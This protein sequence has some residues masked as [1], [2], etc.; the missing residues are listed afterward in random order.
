MARQGRQPQQLSTNTKSSKSK[1]GKKGGNKAKAATPESNNLDVYS[2]SSSSKRPRGD[3]DPAARASFQSGKGKNKKGKGKARQEESEEEDAEELASDGDD[4][5][6]EDL[7]SE[8]EGFKVRGNGIVEFTGMKPAGLKMGM[9]SDEEGGFGSGDDEDI[10]SDFSDEMSDETPKKQKKSVQSSKKSLP[11]TEIDLD[12]DEVDSEDEE[13]D[14]F[15]DV[16]EVFDREGDEDEEDSE[17]DS[18]SDEEIASDADSMDQDDDD[19]D[20]GALDKLDDFVSGLE[21]SKKRKAGDRNEDDSGKKKKRVILKERTEA[22]PEGEF[23]AVG[24]DSAADNRVQLED[25]LS[26]FADSKNPRL[27]NLRKTLKPLA[28]TAESNLA[29]PT[30]STSALKRAGPISAPLPPRLQ[31]KVDREAAYEKTKEE[32][33]KWNDTVKKMKGESGAGVSGAR[34][35]R[36]VLPLIDPT[37]DAKRA[38]NSNELNAKFQPTND[39][40][41]SI[42]AL[43]S[44]GQM[45]QTDLE[46]EEKAQLATLDPADLAARRAELRR[47][48]DLMY[49][50]E[51]KA[52]RVAKIKSKAYRRIHRK[53]KDK[54]GSQL[55]LEDLEEL[56]RIDGGDRVAEERARLEV[57]RAKERATLKHS[58]K[59]GRW[60]KKVDGLDGLEDERNKSI[61]DMVERR[62]QLRKKIAGIEDE[63]EDEFAPS[64]SEDE[65]ASGDDADFDSIRKTAF[66]ELAALDAKEA[67]AAE[68]DPKLKGVMNMK[69]MKDARARASR[70]V[71]KDA[72]EL[73]RKLEQMDKAGEREEDDEPISLAQ[74]VQGNLGRMVFGPSSTVSQ[75]AAPEPESAPA[76]SST[77]TKISSISF[78]EPSSASSRPT[79]SRA[80]P[81]LSNPGPSNEV[82]E[83]PWLAL[84]D[85]EGSRL[86]RKNNKASFGKDSLSAAE[87]IADK[88]ARARSKQTDARQADRADAEVEL[89]LSAGLVNSG[90]KKKRE[91][92]PQVGGAVSRPAEAM[93]EAADESDAQSDDEIDAQRGKGRTAFKQREL[94]K[95]AF[96]NDDVVADFAEEKRK[97]IE[98]DAPR[99][100]DNT[101]P[102]WGSWAGKG[103]KKSKKPNK[104]FVKKIAGI[105][106]SERKDA[107]LNHVIISEK[108]DKKA[109]K[110]M[111]KDLPFPYTSAAQLEHKLRTPMGPEWSTSTVLRDQTIPSVLVKPGVAVR[112]VARRT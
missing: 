35:E 89:D 14:G 57:L 84:A 49:R 37:H 67:A 2:F 80:R 46:R 79:T 97:E 70:E 58:S 74:Q 66:N 108:K 22:Y 72:D 92:A 62:D 112:P 61:R 88:A 8:S 68:N 34:H 3:V 105:E 69:F 12:E 111:L 32:T 52:K 25:L 51:R 21:T 59:G 86:S 95:E 9:G 107:G 19:E 26:S 60:A 90:S 41:A 106:A 13:G 16:S 83:N 78:D 81:S 5:E 36:L 4:S 42:Q 17:E 82:E 65:Y 1:A 85:G 6:D 64:G 54:D 73:R 76:K 43:L 27:A 18:G 28:A 100:E 20:A 38:P 109:S 44:T 10:A 110:Y 93:E 31:D 53:G 50:A 104:K 39:L 101:L 7:D 55:S 94:V 11:S 63:E 24:A 87:K 75:T 96:A 23:V 48:R 71:E 102:G 99:E 56:D 98:R 40:E 45:Q 103:A 33:D 29:A 91:K 30:G 47:Q 77:T 15:M